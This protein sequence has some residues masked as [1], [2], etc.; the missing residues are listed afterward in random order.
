MGGDARHQQVNVTTDEH[1]TRTAFVGLQIGKGNSTETTSPTLNAVIDFVFCRIVLEK[2]FE[3]QSLPI[4]VFG[5]A[6]DQ[7]RHVLVKPE[8]FGQ[9]QSFNRLFDFMQRF[10]VAKLAAWPSLGK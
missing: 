10:H 5:V 8:P 4:E 3:A 1:Q 6:S 7:L 9:G 2:V